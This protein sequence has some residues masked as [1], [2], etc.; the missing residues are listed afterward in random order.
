[1]NIGKDHPISRKPNSIRSKLQSKLPIESAKFLSQP[2]GELI[3]QLLLLFEF[4]PTLCQGTRQL[5]AAT[6]RAAAPP[7]SV[8]NSRPGRDHELNYSTVHRSKKRTLMS[9]NGMVRP[10]SRPCQRAKL[11]RGHRKTK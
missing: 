2:I 6:G 5:C 9:E 11:A 4:I 1:M 7:S 3:F 10:C 8:M